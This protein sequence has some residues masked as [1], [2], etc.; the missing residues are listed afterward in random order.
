VPLARGAPAVAERGVQVLEHGDALLGRLVQ[1]FDNWPGRVVLLFYGDHV[2][3]LK[4]YA[5]PFPDRSTDY[6]LLEL[7]RGAVRRPP[8]PE[9][10]RAIHQLTWDVLR[11]A[12]LL[13]DLRR[14]A[15]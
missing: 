6:V 1:A 7:G 14:D 11:L 13:T 2:P 15:A 9:C 4:A 12:G 10:R 5:N 3:L 8:S